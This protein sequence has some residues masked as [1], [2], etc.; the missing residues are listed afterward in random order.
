MSIN[1]KKVGNSDELAN[2]AALANQIWHECFQEI[3][4][5][6]QIDHMVEKYQ[7]YNAMISQVKTQNYAYFT[8]YDNDELIGYF[9][10]KPESDSRFFLSKLYLRKDKRGRGIARLMFGRIVS[11]ARCAGKD[12]VYLTVNKRNDHA[13]AVYK[14]FGFKIINSPVTDIGGGF[15]MDDFV[16]EYKL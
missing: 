12:T 3:I 2:V 14:K 11:E 15:V 13:V 1:I 6:A 5:L 7:S 8:V 10:V 16:M 9:T 4:T